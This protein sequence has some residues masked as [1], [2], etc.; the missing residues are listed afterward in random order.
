MSYASYIDYLEKLASVIITN[1]QRL[2]LPPNPV[3]VFDI[4]D[5][6][7]HSRLN[8]PITPMINCYRT[9]KALGIGIQIVTARMFIDEVVAYTKLQL[10]HCGI[11]DDTIYFRN[12]DQ[13]DITQYKF[14]CR[15]HIRERGLNT[16][17]SVGDQP[18][19]IGAYG[20]LGFIVPTYVPT[21]VDDWFI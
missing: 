21:L 17:A 8:E 5:T 13:E 4:D 18:W 7:I 14:D 16:I 10:S 12:P 19:D 15:R 6:L 20:G 9:L 11:S 2:E 3:V 1:I